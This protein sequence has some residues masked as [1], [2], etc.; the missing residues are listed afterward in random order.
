M[1][2]RTSLV[3]LIRQKWIK[4]GQPSLDW[5]DLRR[6]TIEADE[7]LER[8]GLNPAEV[9]RKHRENN[10]ITGMNQYIGGFY[11]YP[12]CPSYSYES[13]SPENKTL[14]FYTPPDPDTDSLVSLYRELRAGHKRNLLLLETE[15][16]GE[17]QPRS[18]DQYRIIMTMILSQ[19]T[20]DYELSVALG[21]LFWDC[22]DM[23]SFGNLNSWNE[24][25]ALLKSYG[26]QVDGP[27][28]YNVH[29]FWTFRQCYFGSW[30]RRIT[31]Q[32]IRSLGALPKPTGFGAT[33]V[34]KLLAYCPL[35]GNEP[36]DRD[37][38]PLDGKALDALHS[39]GFY[40]HDKN[41]DKARG[42]I[43]SNLKGV[44]GISLIDLHEMLRFLGQ[45]SGKSERNATSVVIGWNAWRLLCANERERIGTDWKWL[46]ENLVED[47]SIAKK[48]CDFYRQVTGL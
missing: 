32:H 35:V 7:E 17:L 36:A 10:N 48:L 27:A 20:S 21:R 14:A 30:N 26:F 41:G 29:R 43:E 42:D 25:K 28:E 9:F 47:E 44:T 5:D 45:T 3:G 23:N 2:K 24:A 31:E 33:S 12:F 1:A 38:L 22:P 11:K 18:R 34:R 40:R 6:R 15:L 4:D 46:Q 13:S 39:K 37:V 8:I 16:S 19:R